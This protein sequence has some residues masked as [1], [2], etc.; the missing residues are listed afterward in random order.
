[1]NPNQGFSSGRK[2]AQYSPEHRAPIA[3]G[4]KAGLKVAVPTPTPKVNKLIIQGKIE[5][6]GAARAKARYGDLL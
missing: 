2:L 1:M 6:A 3:Q 4:L 5:A